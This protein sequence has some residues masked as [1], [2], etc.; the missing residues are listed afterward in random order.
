MPQMPGFTVLSAKEELTRDLYGARGRRLYFL[1]K[2]G[3]P[4][5]RAAF[6]SIPD[7]R[8]IAAGKPI[9]AAAILK[10]FGDRAIVSVRASAWHWDWG[11][12]GTILNVGLND[13]L[14]AKISHSRGAE[15]AATL[16]LRF[17]LAY[18]LNVARLDAEAFDGL[19]EDTDPVAALARAL[20]IYET[21]MEE[22]FP[23]DPAEQLGNV[24]RS[25][26]RAWEGTTARIL[27]QARGAPPDAGLALI[28]QRMA[29][30]L[31]A[32]ESGAG[33]I[34]FVNPTTGAPHIC[35]RYLAQ[36]QGREALTRNGSALFLTSDERGPSLQDIYPDALDELKRFGD[37]ARRDSRDALS[38]DFTIEN[39]Q[40]WLLD[41]APAE[42]SARAAVRI[43]TDLAEEGSI[44]RDDALM[45]VEPKM[46]SEL[47]HPQVDPAFKRDVICSGIAAS[48]GAACGRIVFSAFAAQASAARDEACI[49]V[50]HET[51]PEDIR[52]MHSAKA[53]LTERGGQ[54]SHA[55]VIARGL[56]LPC[57]VSASGL[58]ID[59]R[60]R[61]MTCG[62]GRVFREGDIITV[63][64]TTGQVLNGEAN[65]VQPG[66]DEGFATFM[67][68]ARETGGIGVRANADTPA[69]A[70]VAMRFGAD[71]IGLA[72]T[73]H[74][75]FEDDRLT[76]MRE[77]IFADRESDRRA[78]LDR[79]LPMQRSD[80]VE[81]FRI[82]EGQPVCIRL[83][84]LPLHEFLPHYRHGLQELAE[85]MNLPVSKVNA[86]LESFIEVNPMLGMRGV[87]LGL[88]YPEIYET[89]CRAIFE[90]TL[91]ASREGEAP[92]VPEIMI[93]M[94]SAYRE[95]ELVK[96]RIDGI[97]AE[98]QNRAQ[99]KFEYRLGAMVETPRAALRAGELAANAAFLSFGTNDLTQM[100]YGL[101]RDDAGRF[102]QPYVAH[103]VFHE[104]PFHTLD[105]DGVGELLLLAA[106]RGRARRKSLILSVCGEHGGDPASVA[107]CAA[108]R[109]D[110]VS[111]SPFRVPVAR[112]AA[113]QHAIRTNRAK[114]S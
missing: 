78:A 107:F 85:A 83:F 40:V 2:M 54:T 39:G 59:A 90:A 19:P 110:Y 23:Q 105:T 22:P 13:D 31:G 58:R 57:I 15:N 44:T 60:A 87:R 63:D 4:V 114:L 67:S 104:D 30:G 24:I 113:A 102:M 108:A 36:A 79:L 99:R 75:F 8:L 47:L 41:A 51:G 32:G 70:H 82:M 61:T 84:D 76:V 53:V 12:P 35:G 80:F 3:M 42:R 65:M 69:D 62:S 111:C 38:F 5:P 7:V 72:R 73:E 94:V 101:S 14:H 81:L 28:V 91:E 86:R 21:E 98:V 18:A 52:G 56:G 109:F 74:M 26:A 49:L 16:Y 66:L 89:Q 27:R 43:A 92:V 71:G 103:Q 45:S 33:V 100:A 55:A 64:G 46:I 97:A 95:V 25:M 77:V 1:N 20:E 9:D 50:K 29:I 17:V 112:L 93:P 6:I 11:G 96:T 48:P 68:W 37:Q 106:E 10:T 88:V 34:Q